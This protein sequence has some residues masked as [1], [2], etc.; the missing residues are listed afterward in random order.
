MTSL[1]LIGT[2]LSHFTRKL[3]ILLAELGVP[4]TFVRAPGVLTTTPDTYGGNPLMRVPTLRDGN[5]T[6]FDS[7]HIA[8]YLVRRHDPADR[9]GVL[10]ERVEDLNRLTL[11][12]GVMANEVVII[13][14][15][16]AGLEDI[17]NVAYFRKLGAAIDAALAELDHSVDVE[18][19]GFDYRDIALVCMWQHLGHYQLRPGLAGYTRIA[20]RVDRLAAQPSIAS[21][22]PVASLAEATAAGWQ[23]G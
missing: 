6:V 22:T 4:F 16:R 21:T 3:R 23:P 8:R 11:I 7:E 5:V 14:A 13:L 17:D 18:A 1:Q 19:P 15:R 12:N 2:P 9:F 20:A 10:R